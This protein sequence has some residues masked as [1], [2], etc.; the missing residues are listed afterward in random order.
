MVLDVKPL[1]N[2]GFILI[3]FAVPFSPTVASYFF[4]FKSIYDHYEMTEMIL[5]L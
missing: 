1:R 4:A 2:Q 5:Q 3:F